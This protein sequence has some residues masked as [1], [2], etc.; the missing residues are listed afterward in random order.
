MILTW[1][2]RC[3]AGGKVFSVTNAGFSTFTWCR[4][5]AWSCSCFLASSTSFA[6][7]TPARPGRECPVYCGFSVAGGKVFSV[8]NAGF[9]TFTWCRVVAWS[10]SC[11][12]AS[13]TSFA[14][15]TPARPGRECPVY[16]GFNRQNATLTMICFDGGIHEGVNRMT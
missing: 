15:F 14:A 5:V 9:S 6:A 2:F 16:C 3:V 4:V 7:F 8:T 1:A 10:C 13:S 11:F 12:L